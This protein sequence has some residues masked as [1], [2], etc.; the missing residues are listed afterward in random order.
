MKL[1]QPQ[2]AGFSFRAAV[3]ASIVILLGST[4]LLFTRLG[5]YATWDDEAITAMTARAVWQTGDTS[6]RVDDHN[7]L[8]Y[9]NGLLVRNFKD[10]YTPPLQFYLLAPVIGLLGDS[11][12][13]LRLPFAIC[14]LITVIIL[15]AWLWRLRPSP[16][17]WWAAA[18]VLLTNASFFLFFRQCRYY[19]LAMVLTATVTYLY[20]NRDERLRWHIGLAISLAALLTTQYLDYAA[21]AGCLVFDYLLWGRQQPIGLR[22]WLVILIPQLIVGGIVCSI[23]N[24]VA[25]HGVDSYHS[26]N[27]IS[28]RLTLLWWSCRDTLVCDFVIMPLLVICPLLYLKKRST[29]L[30]RAPA[31]LLVYIVVMSFA[32]PTELVKANCAE[33]R[34]FAPV[35]PLCV[36]IGIVAIWGLQSLKLKF[37]I[38]IL[39]AAAV[40][41]LIEPLP[42]DTSIA[43]PSTAL[44][45]YHEL[46]SPI[47]EPYT[48]VMN[49]INANVPAGASIYVEPMYMS[50]PLMFRAGKA[51][52]AWQLKNPPRADFC[53]LPAIHFAGQVAPDYM[54]QF[55][56]TGQSEGIVTALAELAAR[57]EPYDQITTIHVDWKDRYR[58][59]RM[60]HSFTNVPPKPTQEIYIYRHRVNPAPTAAPP[61]E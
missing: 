11:N 49:W 51:L 4:A 50:Y 42:N 1:T 47:E 57:G 20:C 28:D 12:L 15:L 44:L 7:L 35:L 55:G 43:G 16:I 31:A 58:P 2:T 33:M 36:G 29:W 52:Y 21:V 3:A 61:R 17:V 5:H 59:E 53:G 34:Y 37:R 54:I 22:R 40:T 27:L 26:A 14:G 13:I 19:G 39:A 41:V 60:W 8:V 46:A 38:V 45:F 48:P 23:W 9:R 6:V 32:V 30:L 10:R 25:R 24:P 18:I 56:D